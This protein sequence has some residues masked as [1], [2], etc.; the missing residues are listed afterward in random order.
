[1]KRQ[2]SKDARP[3]P[4]IFL[5]AQAAAVDHAAIHVVG[6]IH[7]YAARSALDV[8]NKSN[9]AGIFLESGIVETTPRRHTESK[10]SR[11]LIHAL[12][13]FGKFADA[14]QNLS[15][16]CHHPSMDSVTFPIVVHTLIF[17]EGGRLLLLRRKGTGL[18]DGY[19]G[20]PGGHLQ[21][22][23]TVSNA[24][25]REC[26]EEVCIEAKAIQPLV[27]MPFMGGV[28]FIFEAHEWTGAAEIGEP[29][30]CSEIG[31]FV[32]ETIPRDAVP[33]VSKALELR[34]QKVWYHEYLD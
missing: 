14:K 6:I 3:I 18:M 31:W 9:A 15:G 33:F 19:L 21:A 25:M 30:K 5:V 27:V 8:A 2:A 13:F 28:D 11:E 20:L 16:P 23:E 22:G 24:A 12:L 10:L 1:M 17:D 7:D 4:C 32:P 34:R 26:K 29:D